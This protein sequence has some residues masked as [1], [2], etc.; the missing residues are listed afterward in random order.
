M[1]DYHSPS[2]TFAL[3]FSPLSSTTASLKLAIGSHVESRDARPDTNHIT[4]IGLDKSYLEFEDDFMDGNSDNE[5]GIARGLSG[6]K[7]PGRSAFI[8]LARAPHSYPPSAIA[9]SPAQLS[10]SLQGSSSATAGEGAREMVASSS[11]CL[12]L[13]DLVGDHEIGGNGFVGER[14]RKE[15]SSPSRLVQRAMLANVGA[16]SLQPRTGW[17][18]C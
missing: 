18:T 6:G 10:G 16:L 7:G 3:A 4:V 9:F 8:P 13:W 12:R 15:M 14:G 17:L 2:P 11:D 5:L 1:L